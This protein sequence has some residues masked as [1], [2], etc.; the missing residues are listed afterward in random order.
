MCFISFQEC[1]RV[2]FQNQNPASPA[3]N[4]MPCLFH[5]QIQSMLEVSDF[6]IVA[7]R[8]IPDSIIDLPGEEMPY[9]ILSYPIHA[10]LP[11]PKRNPPGYRIPFHYISY[12][13]SIASESRRSFELTR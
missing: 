5:K 12:P 11:C 4:P 8:P 10:Y 2:P 7:M 6:T 3:D 9:P 13:I 1:T